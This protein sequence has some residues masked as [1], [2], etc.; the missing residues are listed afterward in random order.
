M[1]NGFIVG[2]CS[3]FVLAS[4]TKD[5]QAPEMQ[6]QTF[7]P[8]GGVVPDD[9]ALVAKTPL[10]VSS[11]YLKQHTLSSIKQNGKGRTDSDADGIPDNSDACPTQ[12]EI[13]NGY[14]D[15]DGCPD[16]VP[17]STDKTP[18]T[19]AIL[20]PV[21]GAMVSGAVAITIN[22][23]DNVKVTSVSFSMDGVVVSTSTVAPFGITWNSSSVPAGSHVLSVKA[24]DAAGNSAMA[25]LSIITNTTVVQPP[26]SSGVS[27][28]MPPVGHQGSEGSCVA[29]AVGYAARSAEHFYKMGD[30]AYSFATNVFSPEFLYNQTKVAAECGSGTS[31][32][33]AMDFMKVN[34][35]ATWQSMPYSST[36]GCSLLPTTTQVAAASNYK[37]AGYSKLINSDQA[38]IKAMVDAKHPVIFNCSLD[39]S[40]VDAGPGFIWKSYAVGPGVGHTM[41]ICGYDDSKGAYKVMNSW[42]T[43]WGDSGYSWIS[44]D[45]FPSA[46][47]YYVYVMTV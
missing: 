23:T 24:Y 7:Q 20:S 44:Y 28:L 47:F 35:I 11:A 8:V 42:G 16:T 6:P 21:T 2:L 39:Q 33:L 34:G 13:F 46:T 43:A 32:V 10:I 17:Q 18:P 3:L 45:F 41:V 29:W 40:F 22:A 37:I 38:A 19:V 14:Q 26:A 25:T 9:P 31:P 36:N 15:G 5:L 30:L 12:K 1:R 4:C 27:L